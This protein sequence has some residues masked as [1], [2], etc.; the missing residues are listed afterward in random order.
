M[1]DLRALRRLLRMWLAHSLPPEEHIS[2]TKHYIYI[3]SPL[4]KFSF[5]ACHDHFFVLKVA[6]GSPF[7]AQIDVWLD[8][9]L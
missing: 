1:F 3:Q 5:L 8:S 6:H 4:I 2:T 7:A 9:C